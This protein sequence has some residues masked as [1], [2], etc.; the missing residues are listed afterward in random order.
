ME[1]FL[2][3]INIAYEEKIRTKKTMS[4]IFLKSVTES[5]EKRRVKMLYVR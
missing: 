4:D 2:E 1:L 3:N 5:S